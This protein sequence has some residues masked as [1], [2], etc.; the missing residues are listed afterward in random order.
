MKTKRMEKAV[1]V[2]AALFLKHGIEPV[3]M[4]DI[5]EQSG[6]GVATLYR[7]YGAKTGMVIAAMTHLWHGLRE[8]F[9]GVFEGD[10]FLQQTGIKQLS[11]LMRLYLVLYDA[12]SDFMKLLAEFDQFILREQVPKAALYEYDAS[13]LNF[14]PIFERSYQTGLKDGTVREDVN[15]PLFYLTYA[16]AMMELTKK[17]LQGELL[18]SDHFDMG[19]QELE[20]MI[21]TAVH[22]IRKEQG[23]A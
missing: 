23:D 5:A 15:F 13:V 22:Y 20:M 4:T 11:D 7:Y 17:L 8:M 3:K 19:K 1:E 9:E 21:E 10:F 12:H 18:P 14:Y 2:S 16:H 6:V